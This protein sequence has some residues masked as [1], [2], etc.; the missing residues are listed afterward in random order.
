MYHSKEHDFIKEC[1][2]SGLTDLLQ[3]GFIAQ[4]AQDN[5][6][7]TQLGNAIV[8]AALDPQD[9]SFIHAELSRALKA[10]V[11]DGEMHV[12]YT[13][14]PANDFGVVVNWQKFLREMEALDDSG[15]R[16]LGLLGIKPA[17]VHRLYATAFPDSL[18]PILTR[19]RST[20]GTMKERT[21]EEKNI[22]RIY[23]RFYLAF[24]LRDLCNEMP[25]HAVARKYDMAR[26]S[27]QNLAQTCH[28]FAAGMIKFCEHMSWGALAAALDHFSDRLRAGAKADLLSL[29]KITFIKSR[30]A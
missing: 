13:F 20:G 4:D 8:A 6:E 14:T 28:G 23:R 1:V 29:T 3:S 10:F 26:G 18:C 9:G 16:V 27:V 30:T 24:Q 5:F 2:A 19:G 17:V 22:A 12:L 15:L 7:A 25:V 21:P 11:L